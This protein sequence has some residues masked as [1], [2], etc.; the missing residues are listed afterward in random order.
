M[1]KSLRARNKQFRDM[2]VS[3]QRKYVL[4]SFG[5]LVPTKMWINS[6]ERIAAEKAGKHL[7]FVPRE[8]NSDEE[9]NSNYVFVLKTHPSWLFTSS[10]EVPFAKRFVTR[11]PSQFYYWRRMAREMKCPSQKKIKRIF[12]DTCRLR[13]TMF[14]FSSWLPSSWKKTAGQRRARRA[15]KELKAWLLIFANAILHNSPAHM[16]PCPA[17]KVNHGIRRV[18]EATKYDAGK[19]CPGGHLWSQ[20]WPRFH[21]LAVGQHAPELLVWALSRSNHGVFGCFW[22]GMREQKWSAESFAHILILKPCEFSA[23]GKRRWWIKRQGQGGN[24][25]SLKFC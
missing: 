21:P 13:F 16:P 6:Q 18:Q 3:R 4:R 7:S 2:Q 17:E 1:Q 14:P 11:F 15:L 19:H 9:N 8:T 24:T 10:L 12:N 23:Y 25:R 5:G 20:S 22:H